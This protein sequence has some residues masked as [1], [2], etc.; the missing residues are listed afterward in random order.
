M[1]RAA[2]SFNGGPDGT[3]GPPATSEA[4]TMTETSP[5]TPVVAVAG[6]SGFLGGA[7]IRAL[8]AKG[9]QPIGLA[10]SA[11]AAATIE[12]RGVQA[13]HYDEH[14]PETLLA[15]LRRSGATRLISCLNLALGQ[16]PL[17]V[18]LAEAAGI[19]RGI[20]VSTT[21]I[22]TTIPN[23][24]KPKRLAGEAAIE[25]SS[26]RSTIIRPTMIYG[27]PGDRNMERLL[28]LL[29]VTPIVVVP[30]SGENLIQ[31]VHVD[32][33]GAFI[34]H[35]LANDQTIDQAIN[36]PGPSAMTLREALQIAAGSLNKKVRIVSV[37]LAPMIRFVS[38][39]EHLSRRPRIRVE[40]VR[41]LNEDK[42]FDPEL[43]ISLG[44]RPTPFA[45]GIS[46]ES[47]KLFN[48]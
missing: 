46:E 40:Q 19:T 25:S 1:S 10:R 41:R 7:V 15:A 45:V 3:N 8:L 30:G 4:P 6:A 27:L 43:A 23:Y 33:L 44:F 48:R 39:Y 14:N 47:T 17:L 32:D 11:T 26:I 9:Y 5:S 35:A 20:F 38:L 34:V 18:E 12:S 16:G 22:F 37:P 36:V 24:S 31:P 42:A 29:R 28:R 13:I 21:S 2:Q